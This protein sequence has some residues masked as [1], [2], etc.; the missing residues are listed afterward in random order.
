MLEKKKKKKKKKDAICLL[1]DSSLIFSAVYNQSTDYFR[2]D[3]QCNML[4][5]RC[6]TS[7]FQCHKTCYICTWTQYTVLL[8]PR[9][10]PAKNLKMLNSSLIMS[11]AFPPAAFVDQEL[12]QTTTLKLLQLAAAC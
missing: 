9:C 1:S 7:T 10:V 12:N 2:Y 5:K 4:E 11:A 3:I 8:G 6:D